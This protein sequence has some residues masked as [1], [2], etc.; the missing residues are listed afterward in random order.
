MKVFLRAVAVTVRLLF[1][2]L[3]KSF[4]KG[5]A[6]FLNF[7]DTAQ[8]VG[9]DAAPPELLFVHGGHIPSQV[10]DFCWNPVPGEEW[11]IASVATGQG[12]DNTLHVWQM[13]C[14]VQLQVPNLFRPKQ[15]ILNSWRDLTIFDYALK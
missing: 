15:F 1:G 14:L 13:V 2:M 7:F 6:L 8:K 11:T 9:K 4:P 10:E 12:A 3:V 5:C